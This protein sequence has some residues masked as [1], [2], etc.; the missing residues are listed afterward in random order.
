MKF[1]LFRYEICKNLRGR[2][3]GERG[4]GEKG[5]AEN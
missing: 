3:E 5:W 2:D 4:G 1:L